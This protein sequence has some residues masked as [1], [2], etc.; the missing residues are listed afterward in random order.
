MNKS[1]ELFLLFPFNGTRYQDYTLIYAH[2]SI[3]DEP[4]YIPC[5]FHGHATQYDILKAAEIAADE[6]WNNE[7][8]YTFW[9]IRTKDYQN[10][11]NTMNQTEKDYL[12]GTYQTQLESSYEGSE[13]IISQKEAMNICDIERSKRRPKVKRM[14]TQP[15]AVAIN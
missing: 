8:Q 13:H 5:T 1:R 15:R 10:F 2:T 3:N 7:E 12:N 6:D 11:V 9:L 14:N 4:P